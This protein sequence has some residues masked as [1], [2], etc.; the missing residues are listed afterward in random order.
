MLLRF[1]SVVLY[2]VPEHF[3]YYREA[4]FYIISLAGD[5]ETSFYIIYFAGNRE[6]GFYIIYLAGGARR[7]TSTSFTLQGAGRPASTSS[8]WKCYMHHHS[9]LLF[10]K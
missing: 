4:R 7:P 5:R 6:T 10:C 1:Q 9:N 8:F 2:T 3:S